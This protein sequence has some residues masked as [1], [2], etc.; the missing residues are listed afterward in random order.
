MKNGEENYVAL[1]HTQWTKILFS[2]IKCL[3]A[4]VVLKWLLFYTVVF[5]FYNK[6]VIHLRDKVELSL[7]L[8]KYDVMKKNPLFN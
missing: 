8:T 5:Q 2:N 3:I 7:F 1:H 6:T 4:S